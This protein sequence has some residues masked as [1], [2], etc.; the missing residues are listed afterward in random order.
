MMVY[1]LLY[2][3]MTQAMAAQRALTGRGIRAEVGRAPRD[4]EQVS[5]AYSIRVSAQWF[6]DAMG[7][8]KSKRLE[9]VRVLT[10]FDGRGGGQL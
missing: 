10:S 8:L 7:L 1:L 6:P 9:P 4:L 5:C 3:S 2:K